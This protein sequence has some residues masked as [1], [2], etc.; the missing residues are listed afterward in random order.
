MK[1][2]MGCG[3]EDDVPDDLTDEQIDYMEHLAFC[4]ECSRD[5]EK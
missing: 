3:H 5:M 2:T 1:I 4:M